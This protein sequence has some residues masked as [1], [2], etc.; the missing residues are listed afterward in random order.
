MADLNWNLLNANAPAQVAQA[1]DLG[2]GFQEG[3]G[4]AQKMRMN[5]L[6][7]QKT[8]QDM[9]YAPAKLYAQQQKL[10]SGN[11][12]TEAKTGK[13]RAEM[14]L[15]EMELGM[16]YSGL[17]SNAP[18]GQVL[19]TAL[20]GV[21]EM[22]LILQKTPQEIEAMKQETTAKY[23]T[24]PEEQ[25]RQTLQANGMKIKEAMDLQ[26]K[27]QQVAQGDERV[28]QGWANVGLG[29]EKN[30]IAQGNL[31]VNQQ[32][33]ATNQQ[34]VAQAATQADQMLITDPAIEAAANR[35]LLDGTLPALGI[36]KSGAAMK[37]A[38]LNR[39]AELGK[40]KGIKPEE[41]RPLQIGTAANKSA[42]TQLSKQEAMVGAF[43]KNFLK[44]VELAEKASEAVDRTGIP[45]VNKWINTGKRAITGDVELSKFDIA[46][47]AAV[48]EYTKIISGSMGN[49]V[50]A[51]SEIERVNNL[52]NAAQTPEQVK[53]VLNFM[54]LETKNRME[55]FADEKRK[56]QG[57]LQLPTAPPAPPAPTTFNSADTSIKTTKNGTKYRIIEVQ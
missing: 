54:K 47:K 24:L 21:E 12:L 15:K 7:M 23:S 17:A 33:A 16:R 6:A 53:G 9:E 34:R 2:K 35:Y 52:L 20:R 13:A 8:Q 38:V 36:G 31:A 55:G 19:Q 42:L 29:A 43:E 50:M 18:P 22:G 28:R 49:T 56:M 10:T 26:L 57:E 3:I 11:A 1:W 40:E 46:I 48:N 5:E 45:L 41:Q 25:L 32:N 51:Q 30:Q 14:G 44:N 27:G 4:Q 39:V 37:A